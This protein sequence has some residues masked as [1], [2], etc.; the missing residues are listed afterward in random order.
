MDINT[1]RA[2]LG[3]VSLNTTNVYAEVDLEMKAKALATQRR[4]MSRRLFACAKI[5]IPDECPQCSSFQLASAGAWQ[6]RPS[7][8]ASH[9]RIAPPSQGFGSRRISLPFKSWMANSAEPSG[10]TPKSRTG[11]PPGDM[12]PIPAI[13]S[14]LVTSMRPDSRLR[15]RRVI[16]TPRLSPTSRTSSSRPSEASAG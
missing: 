7:R 8:I 4:S 9:P 2:W 14:G 16:P 15:S 13:P 3:H 1:I 12:S 11:L 10:F 6:R 5:P